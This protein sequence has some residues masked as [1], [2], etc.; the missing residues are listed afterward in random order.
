MS[1]DLIIAENK[2]CGCGACSE[3][4]PKQA[5]KM[6]PNEKGGFVFPKID[7]IKCV[8]CGACENVCQYHY[9]C[10][11]NNVKQ[12]YAS[13]IGD[14]R[15]MK[16]SSGGA[17]VEIATQFVQ[18]GGVVVG[19]AMKHIDNQ[20]KPI[21]IFVNDIFGIESLQGSKYA[22]SDMTGVFS[23]VRF[24]LVE[25]KS[26][27]FSGTPCQVAGLKSYLKKEYSN[28]YTIDMICHGVPSAKMFNDYLK[29][30]EEKL[31]RE[32]IDYKFRDKKLG[33]GINMRVYIKNSAGKV[34]E[35]IIPP[36]M[37][38]YFSL[39][40]KSH[41]TR[42]SCIGCCYASAN[43]VGDITLGDY[44]GINTAHPEAFNA[45][46]LDYNKG[47][48]CV[49]VNTEKGRYIFD[50][51]G[52][53]MERVLS[54]YRIAVRFNSQAEKPVAAPVNRD[55]VLA[56]Y[57]E[58]GYYAVDKFYWNLIGMKKYAFYIKNAIPR[59]LRVYLKRILGK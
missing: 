2:C 12:V 45:R 7:K 43:R 20:I 21:H 37:S 24:L 41:I 35:K 4:C 39:F 32:I 16:S 15:V 56:A 28:L 9:P 27:L 31:N 55:K 53:S 25:G 5:I 42:E 1:I 6:I 34:S 18:S 50:T 40:L 57:A 52:S 19:V 17:F 3:V 10:K 14:E 47:V 49:F 23:K 22:Q 29:F 33:W 59:S 13:A 26:V 36:E 44:W 46:K 8:E 54:D 30:L 11:K 51:Y 38:S 48:S 58:E